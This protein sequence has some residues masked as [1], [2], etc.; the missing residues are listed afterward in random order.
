MMTA[1]TAIWL[2]LALAGCSDKSDTTGDFTDKLGDVTGIKLSPETVSLTTSS[3]DTDEQQFTV[4][5]ELDGGDEMTWPLVEWT[6]S[7]TTVGAVDDDGYFTTSTTAGG[8]TLLTAEVAGYS[9]EAHIDVTY[10]EEWLDEGLPTGLSEALDG[11]TAESVEDLAWTYPEDGVA[12]PRNLP[13]MTFM[14]RDDLGAQ[15]YRLSFTS[16]TTNVSAYTTSTEWDAPSDLW[17]VITA[18]NSGED[19]SVSLEGFTYT[20]SGGVV[21]SVDNLW[22]AGTQT[23]R[24]SRFDVTGAVYYWSTTDLGVI[25]SEVDVIDPQVIFAFLND[26]ATSCVGCHVVNPTGDRMAFSWT[27]P[28]TDAEMRVGTAS[29]DGATTPVP[30]IA[31]ETTEPRANFSTIDPTGTW[32]VSD[33]A[34]ALS[35]YDARTGEYLS[36]IPSDIDLTMPDWSPDGTRLVA[37]TSE[38]FVGSVGFTRGE[39]V[40]MEHLGDAVFGDPE[41][42]VAAP[43]DVNQYYPMFS[44]DSEW[45]AFNRAPGTYYYNINAA[46]WMVNAAGGAPIELAAANLEAGLTNSWPR[47]GPMPDDDILWLAYASTRDYGNNEMDVGHAQIWVTAIDTYVAEKGLDPSYPAYR[48]VQQDVGT[49]NHTPFWSAL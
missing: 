44:P 32:R 16:S 23:F 21:T 24:V 4:T 14:W 37:V 13:A 3:T 6:L 25:R 41:V 26:T 42:L 46:L 30:M 20:E 11:V 1:R 38:D 8:T 36:D 47:W 27:D 31:L 9:A 15:L 17:K 43:G 28:T 35:I 33:Y 18:T 49:S 34:G 10:V 22:S 5:A 48:L 19:V 7:N 45:I 39:I 40:V 29:M 2:A 12:L